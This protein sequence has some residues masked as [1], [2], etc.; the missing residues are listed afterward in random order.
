MLCPEP[1]SFSEKGLEYAGKNANLFCKTLTQCQFDEIAS[2]YEVLLI[3]FNTIINES[4]L[5]GDSKV[6]TIISPTTGLDHINLDAAKNNN[7]KVYHLKGQ[8][9]F[10]KGVSG[11]AEL[12]IALMLSLL[13]KIPQSFESVKNRK[14][15]PSL[16]R[17]NEVSKKKIG[18]IG[19]GRL[20]SKVSRVSVALGMK[21]FTYDPY[22]FRVPSGVTKVDSLVEILSTVDILTIHVPL[23]TETKHLISS[24]EIGLMKPGVV[25]VNT[26]R[27]SIVSTQALLYGLN[28]HKIGGAAIDVM[29]NEHSIEKSGHVLIDYANK[30]NNLLI[31]PHIGGATYESVEKTD[32]FILERYFSELSR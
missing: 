11:T 27:G 6:K 22:V 7:I 25:I 14:W 9:H 1:N 24:K 30:H 15:N 13:R 21:V 8:K 29:E 5:A 4:I 18:I 17:G 23:S 28:S 20:G 32:L 2:N 19:C 12:T 31:T 3:R 16:F 10:L 26:S